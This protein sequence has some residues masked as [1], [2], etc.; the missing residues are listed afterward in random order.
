MGGHDTA[1]RG[2]AA[3]S[4]HRLGKR[5]GD[6]VAFEE[7]SFEIGHAVSQSMTNAYRSWLS[8]SA[9][10]Q[11]RA[12]SQPAPLTGRPGRTWTSASSA[13]VQLSQ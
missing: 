4:A 2:A 6:R 1:T 13:A 7:V 9:A 8:R 11:A 3:L 5:F 12:E 10:L